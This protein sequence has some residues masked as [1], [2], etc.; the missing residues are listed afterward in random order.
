MNLIGLGRKAENFKVSRTMLTGN[1]LIAPGLLLALV[2]VSGI[3]SGQGNP[4]SPPTVSTAMAP[5]DSGAS[6]TVLGNPDTTRTAGADTV[7]VLFMERVDTLEQALALTDGWRDQHIPTFARV[8]AHRHGYWYEVMAG[9]WAEVG[10][11][12]S[13][14]LLL[15]DQGLAENSEL[16]S[17]TAADL[18]R[19]L[20]GDLP[21]TAS[22]TTYSAGAGPAPSPARRLIQKAPAEYPEAARLAEQTLALLISRQTAIILAVCPPYRII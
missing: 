12:D 3:C 22:D 9:P 7:W 16:V 15:Q 11:A 17:L 21:V 1:Q 5:E 13:L 19:G 4:E 10:M 2:L 18:A 14:H 8:R 20:V 6:L